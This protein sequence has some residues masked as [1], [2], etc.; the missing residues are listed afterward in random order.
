MKFLNLNYPKPA[1]QGD[2]IPVVFNSSEQYFP[3]LY[4]TL[5][6]MLDHISAERNYDI[7][8]LSAGIS[9]ENKQR[10]DQLQKKKEN[11]SIRFI[12]IKPLLD[13]L[14]LF[15]RDHYNPIIYARLILP[16]L[17][18][19][20]GEKLI[21]LDSDLIINTDIAQ[22]YDLVSFRDEFVAA[23]RDIGM[24]TVYHSKG[25][26]EKKYLDQYLHLKYPDNYF[27]SGVL[28]FHLQLFR[29]TY[30]VDFLLHYATKQKWIGQD[31][32]IF[33]TLCDGRALLLPQEW[34][35]MIQFMH[36]DQDLRGRATPQKLKKRYMLARKNPKII[37]YIENKF[38][39]MNP[40][41]DLFWYFWKVAR[42]TPYYELL[43]DRMAKAH[44]IFQPDDAYQIP[45]QKKRK[46]GVQT[47]EYE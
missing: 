9:K 44:P 10:A 12:E 37:H 3:Y 22:L 29:E 24:I 28:V 19:N 14:H 43:L 31:Q 4:V 13:S 30:P 42:K 45:K 1:F 8:I 40:P 32:D 27:N 7:T 47:H 11:C 21:Y 26:L 36:T 2:C 25:R 38:L 20:F 15:V 6:S 46:R 17:M 16:E 41:C 33:S 35:V 23:V 18:Q 39:L 34:N 5:A